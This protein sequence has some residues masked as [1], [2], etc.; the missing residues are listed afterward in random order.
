MH[1]Q[2]DF[3]SQL[4]R[5]QTQLWFPVVSAR[6]VVQTLKGKTGKLDENMSKGTYERSMLDGSPCYEH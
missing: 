3:V 1:G 6:I 5:K 2:I 4:D